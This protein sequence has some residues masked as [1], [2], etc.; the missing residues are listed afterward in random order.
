M[1][2]WRRKVL[3]FSVD[4]EWRKRKVLGI[5]RMQEKDKCGVVLSVLLFFFSFF[6]S[7]SFFIYYCMLL[8]AF[9]KFSFDS[10]HIFL[11]DHPP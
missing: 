10:R 11:I 7:F 1:N 3:Y 6:W 8:L 5:T 2:R 4:G 9:S